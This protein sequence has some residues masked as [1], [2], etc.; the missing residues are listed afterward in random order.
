M[1]AA[2]IEMCYK[3]GLR[4]PWSKRNSLC[5]ECMAEAEHDIKKQI[6]MFGPIGS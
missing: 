2:L 3:C 4:M 5:M 1:S 6:E